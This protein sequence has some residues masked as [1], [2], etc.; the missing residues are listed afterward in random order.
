MHDIIDSPP[1]II[2]VVLID[3]NSYIEIHVN[4][5]TGIPIS[6]YTSLLPTIK[7]T[8]L[9][10]IFSACRALKRDLTKPEFALYC[11]HTT[12]AEKATK[13]TIS[14]TVTALSSS[15]SSKSQ[16]TASLSH[17]RKY[18]KCDLDTAGTYFGPLEEQKH[19]I[20]F[21][22]PKGTPLFAL[23]LTLHKSY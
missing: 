17:D 16:H 23:G 8:I 7:Q 10:G 21:G 12:P 18:W 9:S 1:S 3:F 22:K 6:E 2:S 11:S 13:V 5:T 14:S 20:L 15:Q 4:A 19:T